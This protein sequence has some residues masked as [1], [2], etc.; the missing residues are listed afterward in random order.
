[1]V[2]LTDPSKR[3]AKRLIKK[4]LTE[5]TRKNRM[6][7]VELVQRTPPRRQFH[8][9]I[10]VIVLFLDHKLL[11][12]QTSVTELSIQMISCILKTLIAG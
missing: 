8:D 6:T 11:S 12:K 10:S 2:D 7:Y 3:I 4:A 1:M 5:A 9:D